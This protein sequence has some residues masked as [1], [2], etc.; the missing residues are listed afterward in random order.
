VL[1]SEQQI[2]KCDDC[3]QTWPRGIKNVTCLLAANVCTIHATFDW[4]DNSVS[5]LNSF[6]SHKC[7]IFCDLISYWGFHIGHHHNPPR[8]AH[9]FVVSILWVIQIKATAEFN[10]TQYSP[11]FVQTLLLHTYYQS[12]IRK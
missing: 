6:W 1:C 11:E 5:I 2:I 3:W 10:K 8:S 4:G 9:L 12:E 7:L